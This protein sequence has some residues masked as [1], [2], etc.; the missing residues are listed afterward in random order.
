MKHL[1]VAIQ[2]CCHGELHNIYRAISHAEKQV[3][4]KVDLLLITGDFQACRNLQDLHCMAVPQKYRRLGDFHEYYS[5]QRKA[6]FLTVF[7]GGNHEASNYLSELTYGGWVAPRI[8]F[9]G[10]S[11][12]VR[13]GGLRIGGMSGIFS[14][15]H[16]RWARSEKPPYNEVA[17][18]SAA[19][20][21]IFDTYKLHQIQEPLDIML[22]HDWPRG[23]ERYG[24]LDELLKW[25]K[26]LK[27]DIER[28]RLGNPAAKRLLDKLRPRF[29][30]SSHLH[31]KYAAIYKHPPI[32]DTL[33]KDAADVTRFLSLDK[34]L[35]GRQ[36]MQIIEIPCKSTLPV[37]LEYDPEWLAIIRALP[38]YSQNNPLPSTDEECEVL[39]SKIKEEKAWV[40]SN[41][42]SLKIPNNFETIGP[43]H[44]GAIIDR[45][46]QE[47]PNPQ[48]Q[49]FREMLGIGDADGIM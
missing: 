33:P 48:T 28:E 38:T 49:V 35:P 9:L 22:S 10:H 2:G 25:K 11:G 42:S 44:S 29:W 24:N 32:A 12:V 1:T 5:G 47:Y 30:F 18:R 40:E 39:L 26:Y 6:P 19:H 4:K 21:R 46:P 16:Y 7:I 37:T 34:C 23:I 8:Y 36:H 15:A 45:P 41:I 27:H 3:G 17:K 14:E 31:V 43:V 13:V 20:V